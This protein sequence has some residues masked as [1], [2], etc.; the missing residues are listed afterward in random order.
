MFLTWIASVDKK[1]MNLAGLSPIGV[2]RYGVLTSLLRSLRSSVSEFAPKIGVLTFL[3]RSEIIY[4]IRNSTFSYLRDQEFFN[5]IRNSTFS[6][7][8]DQEFFNVI[9]NSL[10]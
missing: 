8:R 9:K 7:L 4:V 5:V 2:S 6:Y 10:T 1:L 3:V